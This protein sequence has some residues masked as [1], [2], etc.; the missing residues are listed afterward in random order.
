ME[1]YTNVYTKKNNEGMMKMK[2]N[3]KMANAITD[4]IINN[5]F[6][7]RYIVDN[8]KDK[9]YTERTYYDGMI[10]QVLINDLDSK[11]DG[12]IIGFI[13]DEI[14]IYTL[15]D[16]IDEMYI[17]DFMELAEQTQQRRY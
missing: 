2:Y 17:E 10:E 11:T 8:V 5:D 14:D 9:I 15:I 7:T 12:Y 3:D 6:L 1:K 16:K 4:F 13:L